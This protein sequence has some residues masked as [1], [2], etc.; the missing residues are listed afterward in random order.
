MKLSYIEISKNNL[1]HNVKTLRSLLSKKMHFMAVV[2]ANAYGHGDKEVVSILSPYVDCFQVDDVDELSRIRKLTSKPVLVL[3]YIAKN[4]FEKAIHLGCEIAIFSIEQARDLVCVAQKKGIKQKVHIAFDVHLG[5]EGIMPQDA[6]R[7]FLELKNMKHLDVVGVYGHFANIEDTSSPDHAKK[8][9]KVFD[10]VISCA[11]AQGF[12]NIRTHISA[13]SGVFA[14][15]VKKKNTY[16]MVRVGIGLY[17]LWPSEHLQSLY[18]NTEISLL[19]VMSWKSHI[20]LVKTLPIGH[21][22]GYGLTYTTSRETKIAVIP[23]GYSD[24]YDRDLSN[25]GEV[26]IREKR[27]TVLGRIAMNMFVVDVTHVLDASIGD[28]VVLLGSQGCETITAEEIA[29][30]IETIQYEIVARINPRLSRKI[31]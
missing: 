14:Y 30:K 11:R 29:E 3:G 26:L 25:K 12:K 15:E 8:Q 28:E 24:G 5:R 16:H 21:T 7:T 19:P 1:L 22:V 4:E 6:K 9:M 18:K 23:Q 31:V 10:F 20:A 17:G 27:C 13:T 2:K